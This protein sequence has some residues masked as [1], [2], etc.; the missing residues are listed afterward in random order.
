[1]C[2]QPGND[3]LTHDG[4]CEQLLTLFAPEYICDVHARHDGDEPQRN[5]G[6][7]ELC[8]DKIH[9]SAQVSTDATIPDGR[10]TPRVKPTLHIPV[11]IHGV[12]PAMPIHLLPRW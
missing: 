3:L 10:A 5:D 12:L 2:V 1:M 11:H 6:D 9:G 4:G 8:M 7:M